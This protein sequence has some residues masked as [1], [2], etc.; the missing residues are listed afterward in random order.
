MEIKIAEWIKEYVSKAKV[1]GIV[2]G[3]SG[4]IDSSLTAVLCKMAVGDNL[5][6]LMMPCH[7]SNDDIVDALILSAKFNI[8]V[9][10]ID[11]T[12]AYDK[13]VENYP[14]NDKVYL[15]NIK[16]RLRMTTLYYFANSMNYL[17]C[18]TGNKSEV[19]TGYF[20]KHGDGAVDIS[21]L[22]D[23]LKRDVQRLAKKVG[24]PRSI[25]NKPPSAGLWEG[26]TDEG[27]MKM[28]YREIDDALLMLNRGVKANKGKVRKVKKIMKRTEHKRCPS[29]VFR[30]G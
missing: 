15:S 21:P 7:S 22:G 20:T 14:I 24:I 19:M 3:L 2:I 5:L 29:P 27:E 25:I 13:L 10:R 23:M 16:P 12:D 11:L 17:V 28:S 30:K 4:G 26:Q 8:K 18:G 1:K 6:G 9:L